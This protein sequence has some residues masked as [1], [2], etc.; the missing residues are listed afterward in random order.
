[1][2][3]KPR[4]GFIGLGIMGS[5]MASNLIKAGFSL[6]VYNRSRGKADK[7]KAQGAQVVETPAMAAKLSDIIIEMVTDAPD[8][9]QVLFGDDGLVKGK[10]QEL[11][12]IGMSTNSPRYAIDFAKRLRKMEIDFIDAP[13]TGGDKGARDGTLTIMAGGKP[14]V[15]RRVVPV[16]EAMGKNIVYTGE[17]GTGQ[18]VKLLNQIVIGMDMLGV[19]EALALARRT[20]TDLDALYRVLSTGAANS[21]TVQYYLP[22][23]IKNDIT[24]GFRAIHLRKDLKYVMDVANELNMP[25]MGTSLLLQ[26]YNALVAQGFGDNGTQ[27]LIKFYEKFSH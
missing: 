8:V 25:M 14:E 7:L 24:P 5:L 18:M 20:D 2:T 13:V 6:T 4:I 17:T 22:K 10:H 16:L 23:M 12:V 27:A 3:N 21:F 9:E 19:S 1:M 11:T 26:L 15:F